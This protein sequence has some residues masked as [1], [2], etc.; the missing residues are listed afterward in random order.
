[1]GV[2]GAVTSI[3]VGSKAW[4]SS[5]RKRARELSKQLDV[6]YI[7]L[8][9][10]LFSVYDTPIDGDK[11]KPGIFQSW[12]FTSFYDYAQV[13]LGMNKRKAERLRRIGKML[14]YDLQG[15]DAKVK[16]RLAAL[17]WTKVYELS[18]LFGIKNNKA[19]VEKWIER[20]ESESYPALLVDVMKAVEKIGIKDGEAVENVV[21][22][23]GEVDDQMNLSP[24]SKDDDDD[25]LP[26][27]QRSKTLSF[28]LIDEQIDNVADA[29]DRA[30][31][32]AADKGVGFQSRSARFSLIC[33]D[34]LMTNDFKKAHDPNM[35]KRYLHKLE[36]AMGIKLVGIDE[37][38]EVFYGLRSL[39]KLS[40][41]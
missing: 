21:E 6:G 14:D 4:A 5:L 3:G 9:K 24:P 15:L 36:M 17:G 39:H 28:L 18:K 25:D 11:N 10:L 32:L 13:E 7:E 2:D 26:L 34:F 23:E 30:A 16:N 40:E 19:Y 38:G 20:A 37:T 27:H 41:E 22:G 35:R 33:L 1:M 29:L 8:S 31:E 12:G